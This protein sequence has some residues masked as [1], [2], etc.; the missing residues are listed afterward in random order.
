MHPATPLI[1]AIWSSLELVGGEEKK[2][3]QSPKYGPMTNVAGRR[4]E[5]GDVGRSGRPGGEEE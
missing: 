3:N 1:L 4:K 5:E 2:K